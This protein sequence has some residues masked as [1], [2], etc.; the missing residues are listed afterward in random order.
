[1]LDDKWDIVDLIEV[2]R[3]GE[4]QVNIQSENLFHHKGN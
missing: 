1:M 3:R 2:R 4:E